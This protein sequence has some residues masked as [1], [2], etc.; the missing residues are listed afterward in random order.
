VRGRS[1]PRPVAILHGL[2]HGQ[3]P[4][5][6]RPGSLFGPVQRA[7][8][9]RDLGRDLFD[10]AGQEAGELAAFLAVCARATATTV[11]GIPCG[12]R[13]PS[14]W[15]AAMLAQSGGDLEHERQ[16]VAAE[17]VPG[18][19]LSAADSQGDHEL[20]LW[21]AEPRQPPS[22]VRVPVTPPERLGLRPS[23]LNQ[24]VADGFSVWCDHLALLPV[25]SHAPAMATGQRLHALLAEV[26]TT[27]PAQWPSALRGAATRLR[28]LC[29]DAADAAA[30]NR[31]V[32][33]VARLLDRE[34]GGR[35]KPTG[36]FTPLP[37]DAACTTEVPL[38][39]TLTLPDGRTLA[40]IGRADRVDRLADGSRRVVDWK[41]GSAGAYRALIEAGHEGQLAAYAAA[42]AADGQG[43]VTGA[44]Y[45]TVGD[46]MNASYGDPT[47]LAQALL[48][49]AAAIQVLADG[50]A[51]IDPEG[52]SGQRYAAIVRAAEL[53]HA[54]A[55]SEEAP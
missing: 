14:S 41:L 52:I 6:V 1:R 31:L 39:C 9:A 19:P 44:W 27:P 55:P 5:R 53:A 13:E 29:R 46:G 47:Q 34:C 21:Q 24:V 17:A 51:T 4:R 38:R 45:A 40:L 50:S 36:G 3:W 25:L 11:I 16:R 12:E 23:R 33:R 22:R 28:P 10:Q 42:L 30:F 15:I 8:L 20:A 43:P 2:A 54:A 49:I 26:V 7:A 18:A 48:P 35:G 37:A 32:R